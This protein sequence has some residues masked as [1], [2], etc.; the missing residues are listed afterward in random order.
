MKTMVR[1]AAAVALLTGLI[2]VAGPPA[3]ADGEPNDSITIDV[4]VVGTP[5]SGASVD[6]ITNHGVGG[7]LYTNT[8]ALADAGS[9]P[10]VAS[11]EVGGL[12]V[13]WA[14]YLDPEEDAGADSVS[15]TCT[16][17]SGSPSYCD[18]DIAPDGI[19]PVKHG[20]AANLALGEAEQMDFTVTVTFDPPPP[21]VFC[22]G[23][24]VTVDL[25]DEESPTAG[26]DVILG[27]PGPD[28][29][30]GLGGNDRICGG[31]SK[32]TL[33]G[34]DGRDRL[35]GGVGADRLEGGAKGDWLFGE[36]GVDT[37]LGQA[38]NDA[39]NGGSQRDT[40]NGGTER[41]TGTACEVRNGIP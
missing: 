37:L 19:Y 39:L 30:N 35:L 28:T 32:D 13:G 12:Q 5:P 21:P 33:R 23:H 36:A 2:S 14:V 3:G 40:C 4:V 25:A 38:G 15:T 18:P 26:A 20:Y 6:V 29:V 24:E 27:T 9:D 41:D 10:D 31:G 22:D 34:G 7:P 8:V 17:S 1:G 16:I 11:F